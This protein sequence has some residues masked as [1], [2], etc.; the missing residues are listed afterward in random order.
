[1][2]TKIVPSKGV[3]MT[4]DLKCTSRPGPGPVLCHLGPVCRGL[5]K[6]QQLGWHQDLQQIC[7]W[8]NFLHII[9]LHTKRNERRIFFWICL[10]KYLLQ[11]FDICA[12]SFTYEFLCLVSDQQIYQRSIKQE[13]VRFVWQTWLKLIIKKNIWKLMKLSDIWKFQ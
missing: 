7:V 2:K 6:Q 8:C 4:Q 1:M 10:D 11:R 12:K 9:N 3:V 5:G 13:C